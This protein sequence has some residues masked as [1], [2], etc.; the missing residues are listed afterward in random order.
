M[1]I[2]VSVHVAGENS[3]RAADTTMHEKLVGGSSAS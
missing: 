3:A 2:E 1:K